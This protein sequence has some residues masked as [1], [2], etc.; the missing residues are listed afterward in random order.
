MRPDTTRTT[1]VRSERASTSGGDIEQTRSGKNGMCQ[2]HRRPAVPPTRKTPKTNH[3]LTHL[4][5]DLR[6]SHQL[7][8]L[9]VFDPLN[10]LGGFR[11]LHHRWDRRTS[12]A[13]SPCTIVAPG[14][15]PLPGVAVNLVCVLWAASCC[16]FP[17]EAPSWVAGACCASGLAVSTTGSRASGVAGCA[18]GSFFGAVNTRT[19]GKYMVLPLWSRE[20]LK[21]SS[22]S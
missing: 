6:R 1:E 3:A 19:R 22:T 18:S 17:R 16:C 13:L 10:R 21:A 2:T 4:A 20:D 12:R 5:W 11:P 7:G 8:E 15:G 9:F 14:A